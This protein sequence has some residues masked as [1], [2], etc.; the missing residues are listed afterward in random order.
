M[1][2]FFHQFW[3]PKEHKDMKYST[4]DLTSSVAVF[5]ATMRVKSMY[6][7]KLWLKWEK[8]RKYGNQSNIVKFFIIRLKYKLAMEFTAC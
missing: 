8:K 7:I 6:M 3:L 2:A 4:R 1:L 5:E